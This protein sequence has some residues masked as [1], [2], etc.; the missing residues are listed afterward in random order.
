[1]KKENDLQRYIKRKKRKADAAEKKEKKNYL[2]HL[3]DQV[4][5]VTKANLSLGICFLKSY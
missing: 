2:K 3:A 4:S 5:F 1:M